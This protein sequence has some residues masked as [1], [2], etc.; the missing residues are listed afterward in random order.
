MRVCGCVG[1]VHVCVIEIGKE[2]HRDKYKYTYIINNLD[3][4]INS[5]RQMLYISLYIA[6]TIGSKDGS[7]NI[8]IFLYITTKRDTRK[9]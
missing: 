7:L 6:V 1:G 4:F 8:N 9:K 5:L 3:Y 2:T